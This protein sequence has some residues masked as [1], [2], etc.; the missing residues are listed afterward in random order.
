[1]N[2]GSGIPLSRSCSRVLT[3]TP[4]DNNIK[5]SVRSR[6]GLPRKCLTS[7]P[8]HSTSNLRKN[9]SSSIETCKMQSIDTVDFND[10]TSISDVATTTNILTND[11]LI[12]GAVTSCSQQIEEEEEDEELEFNS[13]K[14]LLLFY[15]I[16]L[17]I[18]LM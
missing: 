16:K 12:K 10:E 5:K 8:I 11:S 18:F 14:G 9:D 1:M 13:E 17:K 15:D 3:T 6:C 2:V 4:D 7:T